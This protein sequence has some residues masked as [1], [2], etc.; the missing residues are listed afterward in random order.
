[1]EEGEGNLQNDE[2]PVFGERYLRWSKSQLGRHFDNAS[3]TQEQYL[4][5]KLKQQHE[6][7]FGT[8]KAAQIYDK[9]DD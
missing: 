5:W 2:E 7:P 4:A 8:R 3:I 9:E 1:M 6:K